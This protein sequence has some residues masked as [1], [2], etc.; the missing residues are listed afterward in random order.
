VYQYEELYQLFSEHLK[1]QNFSRNPKELYEPIVYSLS[2]CGKRLRPVFT[3]MSCDLF[4]G[5]IQKALPQALAVELLHNFTLIHDDLMDQSPI[6]H[7]KETVFK[8]WDP[9]LAILSGDALFALAYNYILHADIDRLPEILT[10]FNTTALQACEGQQLD[11]NFEKRK[12]VSLSDYLEMIR[13]K[14][15]VLFGASLKLGALI[16]D[17][18]EKNRQLIYD[19]GVNVGMGFQLKDD[20]L[21][22][23][24]NEDVFGKRT[25]QDIVEN[26]KTFLFVKAMA[27][28]D[29][30]T[31]HIL[32]DYFH[33]KKLS[34]TEK[35]NVFRKIFD[36]LDIRQQTYKAIDIYLQSG[37]EK[38]DAVDVPEKRKQPLRK[39]A[40]SMMEREK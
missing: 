25:G 28:A 3:L 38:L 8:K 29:S 1:K 36:S 32:L 15:A 6:R 35:I 16:A 40:Q 20:L 39:L 30:K 17:A 31:R 24:G 33:E 18:S 34:D 11:L 37:L 10:L 4:G 14:T 2:Q 19:F 5:D 13:L 27:S 21:D 22:L 23:Y 7:G 9:K 12:E 26:K